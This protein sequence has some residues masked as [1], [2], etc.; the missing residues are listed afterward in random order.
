M[1]SV[2]VCLWASR[3]NQTRSEE[4]LSGG[5]YYGT[6]DRKEAME[7]GNLDLHLGH[8]ALAKLLNVSGSPFQQP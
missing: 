3:S 4:L 8:V 6:S 2:C 5:I 7:G 1:A